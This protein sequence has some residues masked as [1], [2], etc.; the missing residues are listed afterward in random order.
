MI[1]LRE[2]KKLHNAE[3]H[4]WSFIFSYGCRTSSDHLSVN[5]W[6][7]WQSSDECENV[8]DVLLKLSWGL[9]LECNPSVPRVHP[10]TLHGKEFLAFSY[11]HCNVTMSGFRGW[12]IMFSMTTTEVMYSQLYW[13]SIVKTYNLWWAVAL[14]NVQSKPYLISCK[15]TK[16]KYV[17]KLYAPE[18][19]LYLAICVPMCAI[20]WLYYV[21][22]SF[23]IAWHHKAGVSQEIHQIIPC[24]FHLT[25]FLQIKM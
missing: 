11:E 7:S 22:T 10:K 25:N 18:L 16:Y 23:L 5:F 8:P 21:T 19:W 20:L 12:W 2:I 17:R 15:Y 6:V 9:Q 13:S 24:T 4:Q 1:N 14:Q 3:R